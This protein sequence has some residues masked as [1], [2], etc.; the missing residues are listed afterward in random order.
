MQITFCEGAMFEGARLAVG[1]AMVLGIGLAVMRAEAS[2]RERGME[3]GNAT[4]CPSTGMF[5]LA[6]LSLGV[7]LPT[8]AA[9]A[10]PGPSVS[11]RRG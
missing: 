7:A 3:A 2:T 6:K 9:A 4:E 11:T 10:S 5:Y 8:R 1:A